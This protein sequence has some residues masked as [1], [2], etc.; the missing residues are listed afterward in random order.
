[1]CATIGVIIAFGGFAFWC[2]SLNSD[3]KYLQKDAAEI[4]TTLTTIQGT[5]FN[6]RAA[7][8]PGNVLKELATAKPQVFAEALPALRSIS[9]KPPAGKSDPALLRALASKLTKVSDTTPEYWPTALRFIE[10]ASS[11]LTADVPPPGSP[12]SHLADVV[13]LQPK[14]QELS[15]QIVALDYGRIVG[16][17]FENCRY[18]RLRACRN[19]ERRVH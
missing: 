1:V 2:G 15:H 4:R 18:L 6:M 16:F 5:L 12:V 17:K 10:F 14:L 9:E 11:G 13:L 19:A 3:V 7:E 8:D